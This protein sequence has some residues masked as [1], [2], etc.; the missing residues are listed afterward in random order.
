MNKQQ[1]CMLDEWK[2]NSFLN[3]EKQFEVT[4]GKWCNSFKEVLQKIISRGKLE[5]KL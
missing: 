3:F 2:T 1:R 5:R 4:N